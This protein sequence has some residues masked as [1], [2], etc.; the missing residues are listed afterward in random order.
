[1]LT[2]KQT[3][4]LTALAV[5]L[6][7]ASGGALAQDETVTQLTK[8][9]SWF[10]LGAGW[11]SDNRPQEGQYDGMNQ[12]GWYGLFDAFINKRDEATGTWYSL[13]ARNLGLDTREIRADWLRQGNIGAFVE[14]SQ[15]PRE[16]PYTFNTGLR[17]IGTTNQT[18]SGA[19][20]NALPFAEYHIGTRRDLWNLGAYKNLI[21]GLELKVNYKH[22]EK[23]GNRQWGRGSAPE[24]AVEPIDSTTQQAEVVLNYMRDKLQ[25]QGGWY[26][27][28]WNQNTSGLV[29][30]ITNGVPPAPIA[31]HT[32]LTLPLDNQ[33]QQFFL[34]GGYNFTP[35]TRG[36]FKLSYTH[37][38]QNE[39]LPTQSIPGLSLP[40]TPGSLDGELNTTLAQLG[41]TSRATANFSWLANLRYYN[42]E[43]KTPQTRW[44]QTGALPCGTGLSGTGGAT[45][46]DNT[47]LGFETWSGKVEGTYRLPQ[48]F[49]LIG[50]IDYADQDRVVPVG[51][52][53][54]NPV[55]GIDRQRYVPF[56]STLEE[57]TYRVQVRRGLSETI[58]GS[59]GY[60]YSRRS[61]SGYT[62]TN[63][64]ESDEI[65]PIHIAK[66]DRNRWRL[67]LDWTPLEALSFTFNY[68]NA[69][70][71]YDTSS[72]RPYALTKG[73]G[74][75]VSIDASYAIS[76]LWRV[77]AWYSWDQQ[78]AEQY[79]L[80]A[81]NSGAGEANKLADLEDTGNT[82]G[83]GLRG[84]VTPKVRV[85]ADLLYAEQDSKYP[86]TI[87]LTGPGAVF[88]TAAGVT[89]APLQSIENKLTRFKLFAGYALHKN[90]EVFIDYI[91][92]RW[93]SD[94]WSWTFANGSTF[95]Y[96]TT[97]DGTQVT[98]APRQTSNFIGV[99]YIY[100]FQ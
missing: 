17:G 22:E 72:G 66:R 1:M 37:A 70:D 82:L 48:G 28:W 13:D 86:E 64:P 19:G 71:D 29:D 50:G 2:N 90:G 4:G 69:R 58:N 87:T 3:F 83:I 78:T 79:A 57:T 33:A 60:L 8:P 41:V 91:W 23:T 40:G 7:G 21:P 55:N 24:F 53:T 95:T 74:Q 39:S 44:I 30:M 36:T 27:S 10:S 49:S 85:G 45:C 59:L 31:N 77:N 16:N 100:K 75:L 34:N 9:N 26:G 63:E 35:A 38:T 97:T 84:V 25:L 62:L 94:D 65:N 32:Y 56:K 54:V 80:R 18:V 15:T 6:T 81:A 96:G 73:T 47:P 76:D 43:E 11:W 5:A 42:A 99:R 89:V 98:Q 61:G 52:G 12:K 20:A 67:M 92:E 88:P 93:N 51:I 68:E 14:F 46:V